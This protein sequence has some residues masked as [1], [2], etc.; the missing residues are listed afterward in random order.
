MSCVSLYTAGDTVLNQRGPSWSAGDSDKGR[1]IFS[2]H[3]RTPQYG[4]FCPQPAILGIK[5]TSESV[6]LRPMN[7]FQ[8]WYHSSK[9]KDSDGERIFAERITD[10]GV[11]PKIHKDVLTHNSKRTNS[12]NLK[13]GK[14]K[15][16]EHTPKKIYRWKMS[17]RKDTKHPVLSG[18]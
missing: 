5:E 2:S 15:K 9:R 6:A 4:L 3:I 14:K 16:S 18:N 10:N 11:V 1:Y 13:M 7:L 12:P 8:T 17:L